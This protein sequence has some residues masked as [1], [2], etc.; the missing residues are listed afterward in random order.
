MTAALKAHVQELWER[1][2]DDAQ[3]W[4]EER[5]GWWLRGGLLA[6][7][8][9][10]GARP[11]FDPDYYNGFHG[12]TFAL[13]ET[14]HLLFSWTGQWL[15]VA[16]GSLLQ[17]SAPILAGLHLIWKQRD[18][19]GLCVCLCWLGFSLQDSA[20]YIADA[21]A[22]ALPLIS[23]SN[24]PIH[25]WHYL[26]RSVGLLKWDTTLAGATQLG[27]IALWG[28]SCVTAGLLCW[29]IRTHLER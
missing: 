6:Y 14:G 2:R 12:L 29:R 28:A 7:L 1:V 5:D 17:W 24:D 4:C 26:L 25:D 15:A 11:L 18:Y 20:P 19:F 8:I 22:R 3:S 21:R 9:Y 23:F 27:G 13:H 10:T 16:G